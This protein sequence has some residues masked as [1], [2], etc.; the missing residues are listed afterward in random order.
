MH[1]SSKPL[2]P[3]F[4]PIPIHSLG[5]RRYGELLAIY[6]LCVNGCA[7]RLFCHE[8]NSWGPQWVSLASRMDQCLRLFLYHWHFPLA[9]HTRHSTAKFFCHVG[10]FNIRKLRK[11]ANITLRIWGVGGCLQNPK[12]LPRRKF[13]GGRLIRTKIDILVPFGPCLALFGP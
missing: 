6:I 3:R 9:I 11:G 2:D 10:G 5:P 7:R 13:R 4:R 8:P 12:I 1:L